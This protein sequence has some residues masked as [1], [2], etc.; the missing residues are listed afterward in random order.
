MELIQIGRQTLSLNRLE[1][2]LIEPWVW[3]R[4]LKDHL[5]WDVRNTHLLECLAVHV[6]GCVWTFH[7]Q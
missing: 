6:D 3:R 1:T 5:A 2:H 7:G 4:V